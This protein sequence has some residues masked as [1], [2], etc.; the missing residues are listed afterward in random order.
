MDVNAQSPND[1]YDTAL[2]RAAGGHLRVVQY[3][4]NQGADLYAE[5]GQCVGDLVGEIRF[6][7]PTFCN[8]QDAL[9]WAAWQGR[10]G[11]G[12]D[13]LP[14]WP[15]LGDDGG[16]SGGGQTPAPACPSQ[17]RGIP[18]GARHGLTG[19]GRPSRTLG[20]SQ[21]P[22]QARGTDKPQYPLGRHPRH[23]HHSLD[24]GGSARACGRGSVFVGQGSR[25]PCPRGVSVH[26]RRWLY[27]D[28]VRALIGVS[29]FRIR[30][31]LQGREPT[32]RR[33]LW[34]AH[35]SGKIPSFMWAPVRR[36]NHLTWRSTCTKLA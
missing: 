34:F 28:R 10:L 25:H 12:V 35:E 16:P 14:L 27:L 6:E 22:G 24:A 7:D 26:D 13:R 3:L 20:F 30:E 18:A 19:L 33:S 2:M 5:N 17:L 9:I 31:I 1:N 4:H 32:L 29:L 23:R 8:S 21:V 11:V 36:I 15:Q